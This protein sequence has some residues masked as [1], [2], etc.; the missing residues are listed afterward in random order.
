[1]WLL[2]KN[3]TV[4]AEN[5]LRWLRGW[6]TKEGI[7]DEFKALQRYSERSTSCISCLKENRIC[8]HPPPNFVEKLSELKRKRTLKPYLLVFCGFFLARF[9]GITATKPYIVQI[10]RAY[11]TPLDPD[12][13]AV[14]IPIILFYKPI[15]NIQLNNCCAE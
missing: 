7:S 10:L 8:N 4:E 14:C 5:S 12:Q 2:S 1:M 3:R 6:V 11:R 9:T 15:L 13:A